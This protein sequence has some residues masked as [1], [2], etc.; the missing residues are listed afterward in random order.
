VGHLWRVLC[1]RA[2]TAGSMVTALGVAAG[3]IAVATACGSSG[4][5]RVNLDERADLPTVQATGESGAFSPSSNPLRIAITGLL[6]PTETLSGYGGFLT[7]LEQRLGRP[8]KL[9]QRGSYAE[10]NALIQARQ[11][12][13]ALVCPL[14]YVQGQRTFGMELVAAV[15]SQGAAAHYSYL[16]VA[17]DSDIT[18]LGQLRG[19]TFAFSDPNSHSG[20]LAPAYQLALQ[21]EAPDTFFARHVFT[22]H[23]SES[24]RAVANRLVDGA[25][26][27]SLIYDY[28][29]VTDP[30]LMGRTRVIA[31]WG[32]YPSPPFVVH[33]DL[34]PA[35][36]ERLRRILLTMGQ[37]PQGQ[38]VLGNLHMEGFAAVADG[39]YELI[40]SMEDRVRAPT[41]VSR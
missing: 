40:R 14:P 24:L 23:H 2:G 1:E 12:D 10:L 19:K 18:S 26:V 36:K 7:Y 3:L 17:A 35:V 33:P 38:Q 28:L 16:V 22:Y 27:D 32:P 21:G 15:V 6:S 13:M 30:E 11:V 31:R 25:A 20:W 8:V 5:V 41:S 34:D 9:V 29:T 4:G 37:D 39:A